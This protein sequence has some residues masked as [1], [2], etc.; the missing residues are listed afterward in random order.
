[1]TAPLPAVSNYP[2]G[3]A[4][5]GIRAWLAPAIPRTATGWCIAA[6]I[7]TASIA[8]GIVTAMMVGPLPFFDP[9]RSALGYATVAPHLTTPHAP[10]DTLSVP[11]AAPRTR[12]V[13]VVE[14]PAADAPRSLVPLGSGDSVA[15]VR[16][17]PSS[18]LGARTAAPSTP[19]APTTTPSPTSSAPPSST[20]STPPSASSGAPIPSADDTGPQ[21]EGGRDAHTDAHDAH[22]G[23][24]VDPA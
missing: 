9:L 6:Y 11:G 8:V 23:G 21:P 13:P 7:G 4:P 19:P 10:A 14:T 18:G 5:S 17:A 15:P 1:M 16:P 20:G 2:P 12:P 24:P 22:P 3:N